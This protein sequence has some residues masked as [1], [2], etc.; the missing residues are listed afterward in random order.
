MESREPRIMRWQRFQYGKLVQSVGGPILLGAEHRCTGSSR[1]FPQ[2]LT[3]FCHPSKLGL[4]ERSWTIWE[5][6]PWASSGGF[7]TAIG[8]ADGVPWVIIV[9]QRERSE[10][11]DGIDGR[12]YTEA[13]YIAC[14]A[15]DY[16]PAVLS[17]VA[18]QLHAEPL[19]SHDTD[20]AP[21]EVAL[22][23]PDRE[24]PV[25]WLTKVSTILRS[26]ISGV[27]ISIQDWQ[28]TPEEFVELAILCFAAM[29]RT[30]A[31]RVPFGAG[32]MTMDGTMAFASGMIAR[33][34][35]RIVGGE[36]KNERE[37]DLSI[38]DKYLEWLKSISG[39][40]RTRADLAKAIANHLPELA[41][42]DAI[43]P[44]VPWG[45]AAKKVVEVIKEW[46][47][48]RDLLDLL[49]KGRP[50]R[51][52][53]D[54]EYLR[55]SVLAELADRV[56]TTSS[57]DVVDLL[58]STAAWKEEWSQFIKNGTGREVDFRKALA[59]LFGAN[60]IDAPE[61]LSQVASVEL[62]P[63]VR[64]ALLIRLNEALNRADSG[65][66]WVPLVC[67]RSQA[68]DWV[69]VWVNSV[70]PRLV[71][72]GLADF[73]ANRTGNH[74]TL[75]ESLQEEAVTKM[76]FNLLEWQSVDLKA[77][78]AFMGNVT[79]NDV[80]TLEHLVNRVANRSVW[81]ALH[82]AEVAAERHRVWCPLGREI[83]ND[84]PRALGSA[85][86]DVLAR[87]LLSEL[88]QNERLSIGPFMTKLLLGQWGLLSSDPAA[89]VV[90]KR[91]APLVGD[92]YATVAFGYP[93]RGQSG[94]FAAI[95]RDWL[96]KSSSDESEE[97]A[98]KLV[99]HFFDFEG[100]N[101]EV[102]LTS[103]QEWYKATR[104][105]PSNAKDLGAT[106]NLYIQ[107]EWRESV[108]L[109]EKQRLSLVIAV[110]METR[111]SGRTMSLNRNEMAAL[112]DVVHD[113]PKERAF[114]VHRI[115]A[116]G[117]EREEG[118]R[119]VMGNAGKCSSDEK[120][121]LH[122]VSRVTL[123]KLILKDFP[124]PRNL[125]S[126]DR[127]G[128]KDVNAALGPAKTNRVGM[129][130]RHDLTAARKLLAFGKKAS[131][132]PLLTAV[133][134]WIL[135]VAHAERIKRE[136]V[137]SAVN[138][139]DGFL[140]RLIGPKSPPNETLDLLKEVLSELR[141]ESPADFVKA[142]WPKDSSR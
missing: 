110:N 86:L 3:K 141:P 9:R 1:N 4:G 77:L 41:S 11:G 38:G 139:K 30:L 19:M 91:L 82:L 60:P 43:K 56:A 84:E 68:A 102:I 61:M 125:S 120:E 32:M 101:R 131:S 65:M 14:P 31:W 50:V 130:M 126:I 47:R 12:L 15:P 62:S 109:S 121:A 20:L 21:L 137:E 103:L 45:N 58:A 33:G 66:P 79:Q 6:C 2:E 51:V 78:E 98:K 107:R 28:T 113:N 129:Q 37:Y 133:A 42:F 97:V 52:R 93:P 87:A 13:H 104:G 117:W 135:S 116:R 46:E 142:H 55:G 64:D 44:E 67:S 123:V 63:Q 132:K 24:L 118:W 16:D 112:L 136:D 18:A 7:A 111:S 81:L 10:A 114:W 69:R 39:T 5:K 96:K 127:I 29:P 23:V 83:M 26:V 122:H 72:L 17:E 22:D 80:N 57:R 89:D 124:I 34:G 134:Q 138:Q 119:W 85:S 35:L 73:F 99:Q 140:A 128:F 75:L 115:A 106:L 88:A 90:A 105:Q 76:V 92:P 71:W 8:V 40:C 25:D 94:D 53:L 59:M 49:D 27:P 48:F 70:V 100:H 108:K 74:M 54:Y 36:C 95:G